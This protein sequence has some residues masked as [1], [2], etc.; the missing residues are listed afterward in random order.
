MGG[1]KNKSKQRQQQRR[2]EILAASPDDLA[3]KA[4]DEMEVGRYRQARDL[5]KPLA[6]ADPG[7]FL[8]LLV[9]ANLALARQMIDRGQASEAEQVLAYVRTLAPKSG[10]SPT[11][12]LELALSKKDWPAVASSAAAILASAAP[13][14]S[15]RAADA[16]VAA[17][18]RLPDEAAT[19]ALR[20]ALHGI[21]EAFDAVADSRFDDARDA[22]RP[23]ER[24]SVF[25]P[26]K[27]L[28]R[29]MIALHTGDAA[30][31]R[32]FFETSLDGAPAR[33]A[34]AFLPFCGGT[35]PP[36][37]ALPSALGT[38]VARVA[39]LGPATPALVLAET[40]WRSGQ[41]AAAYRA[42]CDGIANFPS[43]APGVNGELTQFFLAVPRMLDWKAAN[44]F[45]DVF[46]RIL[47]SNRARNRAEERL[48][49][50][51]VVAPIA[52]DGRDDALLRS[53]WERF[54][55]LH[56]LDFG[57]DPRLA[58][59]VD[60]HLGRKFAAPNPW[61]FNSGQ[62]HHPRW[63]DELLTRA[64]ERDPDNLD[65]CLALLDLREL[66]GNA[67][68]RNHLLDDMADR[69]PD[70]KRV[71]RRAGLLALERKAYT[72]G[73]GYLERL[74]AIDPNDATTLRPLIVGYFM[75]ALDHFGKNKPARARELF[76]VVRRLALPPNSGDVLCSL[77]FVV[78]KQA[79]V[80]SIEGDPAI[81]LA[82][83][84]E[85]LAL[86]RFESPLA[87]Y[88]A[89]CGG[90]EKTVQ[91]WRDR[92]TAATR[93]A[94]SGAELLEVV[95]ALIHVDGLR[96]NV[97]ID[98]AIEAV[99]RLASHTRKHPISRE[100][101]VAIVELLHA[102]DDFD[103]ILDA[104]TD[105]RLAA[106]PGDPYFGFERFVAA[107]RF[108]DSPTEAPFDQLE[109]LADEARRRNDRAALDAIGPILAQARSRS[110]RTRSSGPTFTPLDI[111][112]MDDD[113]D[114]D[115]ESDPKMDHFRQEIAAMSDAEFRRF[116]KRIGRKIDPLILDEL[117]AASREPDPPKPGHLNLSA[118]LDLFPE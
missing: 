8:A 97:D 94:V 60:T 63:A 93:Q 85:A 110:P 99:T 118:Q 80:E 36:G 39:N 42:L 26:W 108:E 112:E 24:A 2:K 51:I 40:A 52:Q 20:A 91:L 17:G 56:A 41:P 15:T 6:K 28:L 71:L 14:G 13:D 116:R 30:A 11:I 9:Q 53:L 107:G 45:V 83:R 79:N 66:E 89:L 50:R 82:N 64:V 33:A 84:E 95:R 69:F 77:E 35:L 87:L 16:L 46:D 23:I 19:P 5:L 48:A 7:R 10:V 31:A 57:P 90:E 25:A 3:L 54:V 74:R 49:C 29:G 62:P 100:S 67:S 21:L 22:I 61:G 76:A 109:S 55:R 78:A 38:A 43:A 58:S 102:A 104:I 37:D 59:A 88:F 98:W 34:R 96:S 47:V 106:D 115:E 32:R 111:D 44:A 4:E 75:M 103:D 72:K 113:D 12:D 68:A 70:D 86:A 117:R 81:A 18:E 1:K 27:V 105:G 92:F 114:D 65:A 101:A 73:T